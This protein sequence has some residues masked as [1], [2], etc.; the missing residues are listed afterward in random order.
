MI[1]QHQIDRL[2]EAGQKG[3]KAGFVLNFRQTLSTYFLP[4][5][6]FDRLVRSLEKKSLNETDLTVATMIPLRRV[7]THCRYDL[8]VLFG[9]EQIRL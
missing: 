2:R 8:D 9:R 7:R 3:C 6:T 4:I 5:Q 1:K